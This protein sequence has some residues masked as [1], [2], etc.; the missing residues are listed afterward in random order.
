M[1]DVF[2]AQHLKR[3]TYCIMREQEHAGGQNENGKNC[4]KATI[5]HL[6]LMVYATNKNDKFGDDGSYCFT[7]IIS[8]VLIIS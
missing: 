6:F 1:V 4:S 7:S 8:L 3:F 2:F 5:N